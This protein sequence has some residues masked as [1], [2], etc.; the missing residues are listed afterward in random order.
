MTQ[1]QVGQRVTVVLSWGVS[2]V[3]NVERVTSRTVT[4]SGG[5]RWRTDGTA[6]GNHGFRFPCI[7][8]EEPGDQQAVDDETARRGLGRLLCG[9]C[10]GWSMDDV[11]AVLAAIQGAMER[12]QSNG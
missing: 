3:T 10:D 5:A 6:W 1:F 8:P 4:T 12:A 11:R 9:R 2:G 7:R